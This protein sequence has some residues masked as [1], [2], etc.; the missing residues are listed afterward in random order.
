VI[1]HA[2]TFTF[3]DDITG[4]QLDALDAALS[5]L[6]GRIPALRAYH[7]GRDLRLREGTG[8]YAVVAFVD[9]PDGLT[10]Y[11]EHP[12]HVHA[13]QTYAQPLTVS[14]QAVQM[15]TESA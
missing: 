3:R 10:A 11:L 4:E 12:A 15:L 6:P 7:H 1:L 14:R 9:D 2:V 13:V 5:D 8:D